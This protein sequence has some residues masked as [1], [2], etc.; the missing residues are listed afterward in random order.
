M[1]NKTNTVS[2]RSFIVSTAK[3]LLLDKS[4]DVRFVLMTTIANDATGD[5]WFPNDLS[6]VEFL[7]A[8]LR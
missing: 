4:L 7:K 3:D 8:E 5:V 6:C 2:D 1:N